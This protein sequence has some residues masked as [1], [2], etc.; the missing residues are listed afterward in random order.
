MKA[1]FVLPSCNYNIVISKEELDRLNKTGHISTLVHRE[2]PC[3]TRRMVYD[4]ENEKFKA[5]DPKQISNNLR[6]IHD[7]DVA[8]ITDRDW[9]VQFLTINTE[10]GAKRQSTMS[11]PEFSDKVIEMLMAFCDDDDQISLKICELK[12]NMNLLI[13]ELLPEG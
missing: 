2:M 4:G 3:Y 7:E 8:D 11:I 10:R 6:F 1:S 9:H 12:A 13:K 5:L